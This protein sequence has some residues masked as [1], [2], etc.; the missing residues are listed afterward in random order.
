MP[1]LRTLL[2]LL[3]TLPAWAQPARAPGPDQTN[4]PASREAEAKA[5][6]NAALAAAT[7]GPADIALADQATLAL[8][9]GMMFIP[10]AEA[11]RWSRSRGNTPGDEQLGIITTPGEENWLIAVRFVPDGYIRD[12]EAQDIKPGEILE[13]LREGAEE[14][15]KDRVT[16]GFPEL[17]LTGWLEPPSYDS[18]THQLRW[19]LGVARKD[20][21]DSASVNLNTRALGRG[22]YISLNLAVAQEELAQYRPVVGQLLG[23][24]SYLPGKAYGDFNASTDRIAEYGLLG[25]IGVVAAKK[26]GLIALAGVFVLKFAKVG[27]LAVAGIGLAVRRFFRRA[28]PP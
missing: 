4:T 1:I 18:A 13:S 10:K 11:Y 20:D 9:R 2:L 6:W 24:L 7:R 25:L 19:A 26:L 22:G 27:L 23:G 17:M 16:R 15:N 5:A 12:D 3:L 8:P 28:P 14:S 21:A